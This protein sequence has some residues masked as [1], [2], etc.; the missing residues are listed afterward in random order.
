MKANAISRPDRIGLKVSAVFFGVF[1]LLTA[2]LS[3]APG[4]PGPLWLLLRTASVIFIVAAWGIGA[5]QAWA[6]IPGIAAGALGV[7][8]ALVLMAF[9]LTFIFPVALAT[10][11]IVLLAG[12]SFALYAV[13][14]NRRHQP[15]RRSLSEELA[16]LES[17]RFL[18]L[19]TLV[20]LGVFVIIP[21]LGAAAWSLYGCSGEISGALCA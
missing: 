16:T 9:V 6:M 21:L 20:T 18:I 19:A 7:L 3:L 10:F 11:A 13:L 2:L 5:R 17:T 12:S 14:L 1:G 4:A 8:A 15:M